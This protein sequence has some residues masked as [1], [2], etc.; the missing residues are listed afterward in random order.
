MAGIFTELKIAVNFCLIMQVFVV[1][2]CDNWLTVALHVVSAEIKDV[3]Y[4]GKTFF[5]KKKKSNRT[6]QCNF[7]C[8]LISFS[9]NYFNRNFQCL[10]FQC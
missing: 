9:F 7:L 4:T 5:K 2:T 8:F 3:V 6:N 1:N 10:S